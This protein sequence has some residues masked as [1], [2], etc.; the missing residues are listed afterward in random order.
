M[1][2]DRV[3]GIITNVEL[4]LTVRLPSLEFTELP[5]SH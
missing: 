4:E 2:D 3:S 5:I 1:K